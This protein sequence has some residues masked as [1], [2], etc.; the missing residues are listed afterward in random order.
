MNKKLTI[1]PNLQ[2]FNRHL[3]NIYDTPPITDGVGFRGNINA[4]YI[5]DKEWTAEIFGNY[6]LGMHWQGRQPTSYSYTM[7]ARKQLFHAKGSLG[8]VIV[9]A[10]NKYIFQTS[11]QENSSFVSNNYRNLP[12]RSFGISFSYRFGKMKITKQKDNENDP[13][14]PPAEN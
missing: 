6:N 10:F 12:Y 4:G 3:Q 11:K 7:A 8:L 13:Y 1:R 5:F 9:N 14:T 2:L